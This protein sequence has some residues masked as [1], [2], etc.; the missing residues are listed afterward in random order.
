M[1]FLYW[2]TQQYR[3][4]RQMGPA[5][6]NLEALQTTLF[7]RRLPALVEWGGARSLLGRVLWPGVV[8]LL[9]S[10]SLRNTLL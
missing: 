4:A 6:T 3:K 9:T 1:I 5:K 7:G 8:V 2:L 10:L